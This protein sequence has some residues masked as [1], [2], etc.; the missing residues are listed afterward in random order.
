MT[1]K[2]IID[3][4]GTYE[5]ASGRTWKFSFVSHGDEYEYDEIFMKTDQSPEKYYAF[6]RNGLSGNS[7]YLDK[8]VKKN[9]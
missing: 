4:P 8:I 9:K 7:S 2:S 1:H 5:D 3:G 6:W